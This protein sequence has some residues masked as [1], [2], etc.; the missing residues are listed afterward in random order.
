ML[1]DSTLSAMYPIIEGNTSNFVDDYLLNHVYLD[2]VFYTKFMSKKA[3]FV[4][5]AAFPSIYNEWLDECKAFV[6][7]YLDS[8]ARLYYALNEQYN[9]LFNVDGKTETKTVGQIGSNTGTDQTTNH[10]DPF[11]VTDT[12]SGNNVTSTDYTTPTDSS[13][14]RQTDKSSVD[15]SDSGNTH[16]ENVKESTSTTQYGTT[17]DADYTVTETRQGNIGVTKSTDL[18][19]SEWEFRKKAFFDMVFDTLSKELLMW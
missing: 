2:K 1:M 17:N 14:E 7:Y 11:E 3:L 12:F 18:L 6:V 10:I 13:V 9:P 4:D 19:E 5:G 15:T 16:Y 8:W